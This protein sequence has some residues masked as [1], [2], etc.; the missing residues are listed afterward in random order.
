M[1]D[2][3]ELVT[4]FI[5]SRRGL[6]ERTRV[7]YQHDIELLLN[8]LK[9]DNLSTITVDNIEHFLDSRQ[10]SASLTNRRLSAYNTFFKYLLRRN[11]ITSNP[12]PL[13]ERQKKI[14]RLPRVLDQ[15]QLSRIRIVCPNLV[16]RTMVELFYHTGTR[17]SELHSCDLNDLN[18]NDMT[19]R[20]MGKGGRERVIPVSNSILPIIQ[21]YLQYRSERAEEDEQALFITPTRGR[22][23]SKAWISKNMKLLKE[24][25]GVSF[26]R[27]HVL[28]HTFATDA[29]NRGAKRES[30]QQML[31]HRSPSTTDIYIHIKPDV[32]SDYNKAFP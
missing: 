8:Y 12:I 32:R 30:V 19:L 11:L 31:G 25:S 10:V 21:E 9:P 7:E 20:V 6:S 17:F 2:H 27:A 24:R 18:L 16:V 5:N 29:I 23:I 26:F 3:S 4:R 13:V 28:R 15:E 14:Q 1:T 22:R